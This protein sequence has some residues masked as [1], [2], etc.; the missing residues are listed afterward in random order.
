MCIPTGSTSI[1]AP[2]I[3]ACNPIYKIIRIVRVTSITLLS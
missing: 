3:P 1:K 2:K